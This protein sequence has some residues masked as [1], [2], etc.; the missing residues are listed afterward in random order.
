MAKTWVLDTETKGTGAHIAPLP[1]GELN[2]AA[3]RELSLVTLRRPRAEPS[4]GEERR[5]PLRF[6]LV[7]VMSGRELARDVD[8]AATIGLLEG[9]RSVLDARLFVR[10]AGTGRWRLLTL[11]EAKAL[12][13]FRGRTLAVADG[14]RPRP[15]RDPAGQR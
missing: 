1:E 11:A 9:M 3:E 8:A 14:E 2:Q 13:G 10:T 7:D 6:R 15:T 12:W 4:S 5:E